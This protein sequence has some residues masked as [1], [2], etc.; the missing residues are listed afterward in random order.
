MMRRLGL[1]MALL[2]LGALARP[3]VA[4]DAVA[5]DA[6]SQRAREALLGMARFLGGTQK[7]SV[8]L[9]AG[10]DVT[11][12]DGRKIEFGERRE[13]AVERPAR[14]RSEQRGSDGRTDVLLF[15][16]TT[17]ASTDVGAGVYARAPQPGDLDASIVYF[18]R[19]LGMRLPIAPLFLSRFA[20]ELEL[21]VLE[22]D[23]VEETDVL[24]VRAHHVAGRT[25]AVDFQV[26]IQDGPRPLPLRMV[27]GYREEPGH[28]QFWADFSHWNLKPRFTRSTFRFEPPAGSREIVFA[29][30]LVPVEAT[31]AEEATP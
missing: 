27:L 9:R 28:P 11:Q 6:E 12:P 7:F 25:A 1:V 22:L 5:P 29:A 19:D 26:W 18:V 14:F 16:G 24:G 15:D 31:P 10:F 23:Y 8:S 13:I 4:A 2:A 20:E 30:Q 3:A 21:R 17:I